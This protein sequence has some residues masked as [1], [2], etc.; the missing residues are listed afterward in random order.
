MSSGE[1]KK[2][3]VL[4]WIILFVVFIGVGFAVKT[5]MPST[6]EHERTID[7]KTLKAE[8]KQINELATL[9]YDYRETISKEKDGFMSTMFIGTFDGTIKAGIDLEKTD[10]EVQNPEEGT[11]D[12]PVV[13][14][15]IPEAK[16]LSHEDSNP[17]TL[18]EEGYKSKGVG[19]DRNKAIKEKKKQKEKEFIESGNL[20]EAKTKAEESITEF[21]HTAYG[22]DV[23]VNFEDAE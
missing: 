22:E 20:D 5:F 4:L 7:V 19:D 2:G 8:V 6:I 12:P 23:V 17:E 13:T 14:V 21:I 15:T 16:I 18:Y 1:K 11:D 10:Y 3:G 9:Q